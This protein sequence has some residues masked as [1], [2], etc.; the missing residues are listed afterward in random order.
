MKNN[1]TLKILAV[2]LTI[3]IWIQAMLLKHQ[4]TDINLPVKLTNVPEQIAFK[5]PIIQ[6]VRFHVAGRGIDILLLKLSHTY[7]EIDAQ[8]LKSK[9]NIIPLNKYKIN[10]PRY[11]SLT[12]IRPVSNDL[13]QFET[14]ILAKKTVPI[15]LQFS[16]L[17]V[18]N[19]FRQI[20]LEQNTSFAEISGPQSSIDK[21]REIQTKP[22][23]MDMLTGSAFKI[24]LISP[25]KSVVLTQRSLQ[26]LPGKMEYTTRTISM[27]PIQSSNSQVTMIPAW[28]S[29]KLQGAKSDIDQ[30]MVSD[31]HAS[32]KTDGVKNNQR[33][34]V[35]VTLTKP[36][37]L[38]EFTP[39]EVRIQ[40]ND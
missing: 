18:E 39:Q 37:H 17:E 12:E 13:I 19:K 2:I 24:D 20:S 29:V 32:I 4:S 15:V 31:I 6:S 11:I 23:L 33:V 22:I 8:D 28:V 34:P 21:I 38:V 7:L 14:D 10:L 35:E 40:K 25:S 36:V 9:N 30:V 1:L 5:H 26:L 27:I 3:F 16:S